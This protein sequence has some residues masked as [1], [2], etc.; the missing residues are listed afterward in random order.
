M[1]EAGRQGGAGGDESARPAPISR[2]QE[3]Q[4][5][6]D[7]FN[8]VWSLLDQEDRSREDDDRMLHAAHASRFHWGEV[9]EPVNLVRGEW[10]VSRVYSIL[11]RPEPAL[12]HARRCLE[13]C[14]SHGIGDFDLAYA[15]EGLARASLVA[16]Q[17]Q[18]VDQYLDMARDAAGNISEKDDRE[19]FLR[20]LGDL[21][22]AT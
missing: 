3:R 8:H 14:E 21:S 13:L 5:A 1:G 18:A 22:G 20:D 4:V 12:F 11:R 17:R 9:G 15:Y 6:V 10:Q 19:M 2:E 7:L 16:G